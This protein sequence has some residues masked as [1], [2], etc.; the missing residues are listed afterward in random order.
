M[1]SLPS[2][3]KSGVSYRSRQEPWRL[4]LGRSSKCVQTGE[5]ILCV[6]APAN[7]GAIL[8]KHEFQRKFERDSDFRITRMRT[9]SKSG[10]PRKPYCLGGTPAQS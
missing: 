3:L 10:V 9:A 6:S 7:P 1:P 4:S 5:P 8:K 2:P